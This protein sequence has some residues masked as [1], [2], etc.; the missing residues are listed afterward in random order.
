MQSCLEKRDHS[1][2]RKITILRGVLRPLYSEKNAFCS[3]RVCLRAYSYRLS[4]TS[5][6]PESTGELYI[7]VYNYIYIWLCIY[8]Y[9][10]IY[11]YIY[12]IW[13][14]FFSWFIPCVSMFY[15]GRESVFGCLGSVNGKRTAPIVSFPCSLD[16]LQRSRRPQLE[17]LRWAVPIWGFP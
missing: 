3:H 2:V 4:G 5:S 9:D 17:A 11:I 16:R 12:M 8:I 15:V 6:P 13:C 7:Y 10:C 14:V 1:I